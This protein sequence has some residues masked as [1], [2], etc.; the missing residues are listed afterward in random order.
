MELL[1]SDGAEAITSG[2]AIVY[3]AAAHQLCLLHWFHNLE[4][5]TPQL[6]W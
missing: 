6:R 1:I 4:A 5:R 3:P 2:A